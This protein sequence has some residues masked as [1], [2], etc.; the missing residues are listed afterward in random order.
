MRKTIILILLCLILFSIGCRKNKD[1]NE[2]NDSFNQ[3]PKVKL[4]KDIKM[5]IFPKRDVDYFKFVIEDPGMISFDYDINKPINIK[6]VATLF[7]NNTDIILKDVPIPFKKTLKA[8]EYFI[9]IKDEGNDAEAEDVF[10]LR[11]KFSEV[12]LDEFEPNNKLKEAKVIKID[13]SYKINIFPKGDK[14]AFKV[15]SPNAGYLKFSVGENK[16]VGINL[17][18]NIYNMDGELIRG[19]LPVPAEIPVDKGDYAFMIFD[20]NNN[21]ESEEFFEF[22]LDFIPVVMDDFEPNNSLNEAKPVKINEA[23]KTNLFPQGDRDC[24]QFELEDNS[25]LEMLKKFQNNKPIIDV[26]INVYDAMG[27][28][29]INNKSI[30]FEVELQK[31]KYF[32]QIYN[33]NLNGVYPD[34]FE[35]KINK[36]N[37]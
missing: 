34:I 23:I 31:G 15:Q 22:K 11:F 25:V 10:A 20:Y 27:N 7:D 21:S 6:L 26:K 28:L 37:K 18:I 13:D 33:A 17:M 1:R 14:E 32:I 24:F 9:A 12:E 16:P 36:L 30:P 3:A 4:G 8:G 35:I 29:I 2:P 19:P 5:S